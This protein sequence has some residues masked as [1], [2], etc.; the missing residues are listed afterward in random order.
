MALDLL[1]GFPDSSKRDQQELEVRVAFG[2]PLVMAKG[3]A[4]PEVETNYNRTLELCRN[5]GET[6]HLVTALFGLWRYFGAHPDFHTSKE[7]AEQ[8]GRLGEREGETA[9]FV[10]SR[11]ALGFTFY[12]LFGSGLPPWLGRGDALYL[13]ARAGAGHGVRVAAQ[14]QTT[15]APRADRSGPRGAVSGDARD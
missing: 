5:A 4:S 9:T 8:L 3:H 2:G 6:P 14:K 13:Q 10:L 11:Y 1:S 12:C 15:T 7:L